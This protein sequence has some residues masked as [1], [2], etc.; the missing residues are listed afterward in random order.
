MPPHPSVDIKCKILVLSHASRINPIIIAAAR[1]F[2]H[3]IIKSEYFLGIDDICI[4][5]RLRFGRPYNLSE[6][7]PQLDLGWLLD[8]AAECA[9]EA[10]RHYVY[11]HL[12]P[13]NGSF[14]GL[15]HFDF[16]EIEMGVLVSFHCHSVYTM[17]LEE[18]ANRTM[19]DE[20]SEFLSRIRK[21]PTIHTEEF[22]E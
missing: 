20:L 10:Y 11:E 3:G 7:F 4:K 18:V 13:N 17:F 15:D 2:P 12:L 16:H 9:K 5:R 6:D 8:Q 14:T 19:C 22:E 21:L 1:E